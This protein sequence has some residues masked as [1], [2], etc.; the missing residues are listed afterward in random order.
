MLQTTRPNI[1]EAK[2]LG[3]A[4][5]HDA[6]WEYARCIAD[7]G[8]IHAHLP[9]L[10]HLA[11]EGGDVVEMGV[12]GMVSTWAFLTGRPASLLSVDIDRPPEGTLRRAARC[13]DELGI[14]FD[15]IQ[16]DTL[17]M[18]PVPCD[19]L[20][21]DT[22]HTYHQLSLEL[23]RHASFVRRA[24]A[25]HDTATFGERGEDGQTPGLVAAIEDL[26]ADSAG[27]WRLDYHVPESNG[28]TIVRRTR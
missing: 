19:L 8:D 18:R 3:I 22:L 16:D 26:I 12:R 23:E 24:I 4:P 6:D 13:A 1:D 21:I 10:R 28:L 27:D 9:M 11:A 20:F 17:Q 25:F 7:R 5:F 15:F 14:V 2:R